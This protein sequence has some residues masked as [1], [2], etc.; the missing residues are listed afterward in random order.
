MGLGRQMIEFI[1]LDGSDPVPELGTTE[2]P[3]L[4][5]D[6]IGQVSDRRRLEPLTT[7]HQSMDLVAFLQKEF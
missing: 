7:A 2:I 4:Q 5:M 3:R 1:R 6:P